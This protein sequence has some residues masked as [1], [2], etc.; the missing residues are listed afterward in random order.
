[1]SCL[2]CHTDDAP[3]LGRDPTAARGALV[4]DLEAH[5]NGCHSDEGPSHKTGM[6]PHGAVPSV[7]PLAGDG[8]IM[9]ATC[10]FMHDEPS[11]GESFTRMDNSRGALCLTCHTMAELE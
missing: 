7:L 9:C 3:V 10:H 11:P 1:M 2:V 4:P 5:C 8:T 6:A